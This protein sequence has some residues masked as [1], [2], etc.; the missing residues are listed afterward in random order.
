M[1]GSKDTRRIVIVGGV[2]GGASAAARARRAN[3]HASIVMFGK[4]ADLSFASCGLPYDKLILAPGASPI[5]PPIDGVKSDN[6]FTLRNLADADRIKKFVDG[7][8]V[9]RAVVVGAGGAG[10][11]A[12]SRPAR[13]TN[14]LKRSTSPPRIT[15]VTT[16]AHRY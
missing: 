3:E 13:T 15:P 12:P 14:P 4:D 11:T 6:L 10:L 7:A 2:A 8:A 16:P 1:I 9:R 5:V